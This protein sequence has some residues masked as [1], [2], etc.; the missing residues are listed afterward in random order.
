[1]RSKSFAGN[2]RPI[3]EHGLGSYTHDQ[4]TAASVGRLYVLDCTFN[5]RSCAES[6]GKGWYDKARRMIL[7][8]GFQE[9]RLAERRNPNRFDL[10]PVSPDNPV[11][12]ANREGMGWTFNTAGLRRIGV[13]DST[14]DPAGG[15]MERDSD[16]RPLGPMWDNTREVFNSV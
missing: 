8:R 9:A 2:Y 4:F 14:P 10:D 5:C 12:I 7:G 3:K 1:M 11:G 6:Y 16:G 15:P 13:Q